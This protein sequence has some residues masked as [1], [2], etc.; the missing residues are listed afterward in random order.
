MVRRI[1]QIVVHCSATNPAWNIGVDEIRALHC[2]DPSVDIPWDGRP[3]PG[4]G[5]SDVGY[6]WVI[7]RDGFIEEGRPPS[8]VGAHVKGYNTHSLGICLVGGVSTPHGS[9]D[10]NFTRAQYGALEVLLDEQLW[11]HKNAIVYGHRDFPGV[12][13][14]CPSFNV[15]EWWYGIEASKDVPVIS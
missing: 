11:L 2:T 10:A 13:K 7:R 5:W 8:R 12:T 15:V 9:P 1:D 6:H 4:F 14:A 3:V